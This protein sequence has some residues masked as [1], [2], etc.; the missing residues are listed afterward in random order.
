MRIG[1]QGERLATEI[2]P[3]MQSVATQLSTGTLR[4]FH[5]RNRGLKYTDTICL[6]LENSIWQHFILL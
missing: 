1:T 6:I 4:D 5:A 3:N 2:L